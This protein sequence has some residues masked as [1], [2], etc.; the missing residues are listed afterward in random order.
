MSVKLTSRQVGDV[1]VVDAAGRI[2]LGEGS[3]L[4]RSTIKDLV[5]NG[6]RNILLN[7]KDVTYLD[8]AGLGE[9]LFDYV[10]VAKQGGE[11]RICSP[12][13]TF[14]NQLEI[15]KLKEALQV[16]S[17]ESEAL[18]SFALAAAA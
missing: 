2:T 16:F 12:E 1:T 7:L 18:S 17:N 8:S 9:I 13:N 10:I 11:L 14:R 3:G 5:T 6:N 4:L 15:T